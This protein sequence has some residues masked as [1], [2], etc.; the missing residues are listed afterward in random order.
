M[1]RKKMNIYIL[2]TLIF[3]VSLLFVGCNNSS[4][5]TDET[6]TTEEVELNTNEIESEETKSESDMLN[7]NVIR[8]RVIE[9][10]PFYYTDANKWTGL[11]VELANALIYEAGYT[12]EYVSLPWSR[13]LKAIE[14]GDSD[15]M[16]NLVKTHER[17]EY[18]NFIGPIRA[19]RMTLVV[20]EEYENEVIEN[21]E[22]L[23]TVSEALG[24]P[25]GLQRDVKYPA[26]LASKLDDE[27]YTKYM[28]FA[29]A[30]KDYPT[31]AMEKRILG[32]VEDE[33][34]MKYQLINNPEFKGLEL[35]PF[36]FSEDDIYAGISKHLDEDKYNEL[37]KAFSTLKESGKFEEIIEKYQ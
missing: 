35:H 36:R 15:L 22:D 33:I 19:S 7:E 4:V 6:S 5:V 18:M 17:E 8:V 9:F 12:P 24:I 23:F 13:A 25:I 11:E 27:A 20:H 28:D 16:M 26:E 34:A 31:N 32:F 14:V 30:T 37:N 2:A 10:P 29:H 21:I 3:A 1:L